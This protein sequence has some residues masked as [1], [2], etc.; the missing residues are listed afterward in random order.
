MQNIG[1]GTLVWA[2]ALFFGN[3]PSARAQEAPAAASANETAQPVAASAAPSGTAT[4]ATALPPPTPAVSPVSPARVQLMDHWLAN[5]ND[6]ARS[7]R[8]AHSIWSFVGAAIIVGGGLELMI[9]ESRADNSKNW[10]RV[11]LAGVLFGVA[12]SEIGAGIIAAST[13]ETDEARYARW[14]ALRSVD[15]VALAR[16]EGEL[17]MEAEFNRRALVGRIASSIGLAVGAGAIIGLTPTA[18]LDHEWAV[19]SYALGGAELAL[20]IWRFIEACVGESANERA[21]RLYSAGT[22]P[23]QA[24][25]R[26][27]LAPTFAAHGGGLGLSGSF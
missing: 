6:R 20:G 16:F 7:A 4:A 5:L 12:A 11:T 8:T 21:Y 2:A 25:Y 3:A 1:L 18:K 13:R 15:D 10:E 22:S 23:E 9:G 26:F 27:Q 17:A 24:A 19:L 14:R